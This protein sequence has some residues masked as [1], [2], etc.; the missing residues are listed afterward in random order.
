MKIITET[1]DVES[2]PPLAQATMTINP[3]D[4]VLWQALSTTIYTKARWM[5]EYAQN[6]HDVDKN[7]VLTLPSL[8]SPYCEFKDNGPSMS[9]DF[10]LSLG[11]YA[12][13]GFCTAFSSTKRES[14]ALSGGFGIGRL[15]GPQGTIFEC[16]NDDMIRTYVLIK[17]ED[18]IPGIQLQS[19]VARPS[20]VPIGVTVRVPVAT[21]KFSQ[22]REDAQRFLQYFDPI[23]AGI[24]P[25]EYLLS[26]NTW[27]IQKTRQQGRSAM[28]VIVGGYPFQVSYSDLLSNSGYGSPLY[29]LYRE[30]A[31]NSA[32]VLWLPVGS[33]EIALNR[34][35][36]RFSD[37]TCRALKTAM[38]LLREEAAAQLTAQLNT[39]QTRWSAASA[40]P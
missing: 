36:L 38:L 15:S 5:L 4:T 39:C 25:P 8:L 40:P 28:T 35:S 29:Q 6:A 9:R 30:I 10:M 20:D 33:V 1:Q 37:Q 18:C 14:N 34:E 17:N 24:T 26:T 16:R 22:T 32:V 13:C 3:S 21:G 27:A 7:W 31:E 19:E 11:D 23:P 2:S 12:G